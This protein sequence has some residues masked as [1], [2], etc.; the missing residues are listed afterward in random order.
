[1]TTTMKTMKKR[2]SRIVTALLVAGV[3]LTLTCCGAKSEVA[4]VNEQTVVKPITGTW[5]NL[6]YKDVRNK[7]TNPASVDETSPELWRAK[8]REWSAMGL[9]YLVL[10]E[11]ANECKAYYPSK[12]MPWIYDSAQCS[13]VEAILD[14]AS[15][16][17]M[18][19]F[20]STGWAKDQDDNLLDPAIKQRQ[21]EIMEEIATLYKE[22]PA[23][24][25]WYLPVEDC[26]CPIFAEHAVQSVNALV[27]RAHQLTPGKK[28]LISPYGISL[29]D[30]D[31]PEYE[32]QMGKLK[33]DIIAYQDEIGCVREPFPLP[34]L[35]EN[36]KRLHAIHQK[37]NIEFW[38]NCETFTWEAGTNDRQ[39][40][41]IPAAFSRLLAQQAAASVAGVDRIVSFM[42]DGLIEHPDSPYQLGQPKWS[43]QLYQHYMAWLHGDPYWKLM[44]ASMTGRLQNAASPSVTQDANCSALFDGLVAEEDT[45]DIH[46]KKF[47]SGDQEILIDRKQECTPVKQIMIRTLN[48]QRGGI[49]PPAK[50][51]LYASN[52]GQSYQLLAI[53]DA[54]IFPNQNHDAWI[55]GVLFDQFQTNAR[56]LK[57]AF[58]VA[59]ATCIDEIYLNPEI[60]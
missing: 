1:M 39:S 59:N 3:S 14:E 20:M 17:D 10:M 15:L 49:T 7:Y 41:L 45:T 33:V 44:E 32:Q 38:A 12:L 55:D 23:F 60:R 37:L 51:A 34:R 28:T 13:P 42:F 40:A 46:W 22:S 4:T 6:A 36:W 9:E 24:Y 54:P 47:N 2:I 43:N 58:H 29:S 50:F 26:L 11:V 30:F 5:V 48:Y 56:Y 27:E 53:K 16:H 18:K 8:V 52:D 21:L 25:G 57:I 31:N 19:V 35:R